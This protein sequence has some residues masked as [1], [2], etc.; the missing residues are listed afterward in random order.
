MAEITFGTDGWRSVIAG[1]FTFANV[2]CV[3]QAIAQHLQAQNLAGRGIVI[4]YDTRFL[5]ENFAAAVAEVMAGNGIKSYV[6]EKYAPT[7]AVAHAVTVL[8]TGGAIMLTASHNPAEYSG[9][10]FIPDYAGPA[11]PEDI[12]PIVA[13]L[14]EVLKTGAVRKM[15]L[16]EAEE[17]GL[18][19]TIEPLPAYMEHVEKLIDFAAIKQAGM[20]VVVDPMYGSGMGYLETILARHGCQVKAIHNWR[21]PLFGGSLPEPTRQHLNELMD[22]VKKSG[23]DI[24]IAL[25]GDADR[26]GIIDPQG[27]FFSPNEILVLFLEYLVSNRGAAGA[28]ARTVATTHMLD[29]IAA[30][31]GFDVI[32][33]PVGFKY[34]GQALREQGAFIGGEES[35]GVSIREHIPEKDGIFAALLFIEM[36]AKTKKTA[37]QLLEALRQRFGPIYSERLDLRTTVEKKD[38]IVKRVKTWEPQSLAGIPVKHSNRIDG[39]KVVLANGSWCLVR[40]SGTEP[41]FRIYVE[42]ASEA[43]KEKIQQEV[44]TALCVQ[45]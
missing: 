16:E 21:D 4:G 23:A 9:I 1:D 35:G 43:E 42:A 17:R 31:Y 28:V 34:I 45:L 12:D 2:R 40:P 18:V 7:P 37:A 15:S 19:E 44:K 32:E 26:L 13:N 20:K 14:A 8:K 41:V 24:G 22:E 38:E 11:L 33:T 27:R 36:L 6:C 3:A 5:A 29:R 39:L 25:D 10:K 30:H